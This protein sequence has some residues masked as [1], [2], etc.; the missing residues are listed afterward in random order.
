ML[1]PIIFVLLAMLVTKL[2]PNDS[3]PPPLILHPWYWGRPNYIFQSLPATGVSSLSKS[4]QG[5]YR[6]SPSLGTRCLRSTVFDRQQYPCAQSTIGDVNVSTSAD[7]MEA[8]N[9]VDYNRTRIS[10][11]CD[12]WEKMQTCP[13]GSGGPS[14]HFRLTETDDILYDLQGFNI[15]DW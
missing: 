5:T 4:I 1:L 15:T 12:C 13:V 8:L 11:A 14:P 3:E 7:V 6:Q 10:P 9:S 2:A